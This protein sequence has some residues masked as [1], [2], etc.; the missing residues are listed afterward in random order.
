MF[1]N[2]I[3][4]LATS[5]LSKRIVKLIHHPFLERND[6]IIGNSNTLGANFSAAFRDVAVTNALRVSQLS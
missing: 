6:S 1:I 5:K 3:S 2:R 4:S